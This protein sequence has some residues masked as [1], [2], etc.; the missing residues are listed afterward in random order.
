MEQLLLQTATVSAA[1]LHFCANIVPCSHIRFSLNTDVMPCCKQGRVEV[2][3][4][5][6]VILWLVWE[7]HL[8]TVNGISLPS[9]ALSSC[10]TPMCYSVWMIQFGE[11]FQKEFTFS[12]K[13]GLVL[14]PENTSY[15][16]NVA[17]F[18]TASAIYVISM[19]APKSLKTFTFLCKANTTF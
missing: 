15:L 2:E 5:I 1:T 14:E 6:V 12:P 18:S 13:R 8:F 19:K 4:G 7:I 17:K 11:Y 10:A 16:W 3:S 9:A